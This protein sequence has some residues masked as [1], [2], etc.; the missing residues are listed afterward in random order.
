V[1]PDRPVFAAL[2]SLHD[3]LKPTPLFR[4]CLGCLLCIAVM[5]GFAGG[6]GGRTR[7]EGAFAR[8]CVAGSAEIYVMPLFPT[9][10]PRIFR[11]GYWS[12]PP[13]RWSRSSQRRAAWAE[14]RELRLTCG[15]SSPPSPGF[16]I[17]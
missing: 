11:Y 16:I 8:G 17:G 7:E 13:V 12:S 14:C 10:S 6:S 2:V 3:A 15:G 9:A 4:F 5:C 1:F